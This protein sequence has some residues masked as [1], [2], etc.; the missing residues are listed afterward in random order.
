MGRI[1]YVNRR[2]LPQG[3]AQVH[4]ED[5]GYQ[6]ADGVYE[7]VPIDAGTLID[8]ELHLDRLEYSLGELRIAMP[9]RREALK[10]IAREVIRRNHLTNGILYMQVTR[11]V[12][13]RDHKFPAKAK[14]SLV[15]TA[16]QTKP[17]S[18]AALSKGFSVITCPDIRWKRPDIKSISL[19][20]NCLAK[21]QAAEAGAGE[22]WMIDA[23][24]QVTEGSSTNAWIVTKDK[25]VVT[26]PAEG[27]I[28]NGITRRVL[29]DL[30]QAEGYRFEERP[31]SLPEALEASEAFITSSSNFVMPVTRIDETPV[32]NGN[33]G[34]LTQALREAYVAGFAGQDERQD[35]RA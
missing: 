10:L 26:R 8:E 29:L 15:M 23:E 6:F 20:P 4:V 30:M 32:G 2:Y 11:G 19:L 1:A 34:P 9:L 27:E 33:P 21:Q 16:K 25:R 7:V 3:Q 24:G 28:L 13:P 17:A 14:P 35:S 18:A 12:A 31:F 22:A 5:R